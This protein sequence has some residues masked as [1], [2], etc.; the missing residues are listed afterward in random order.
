MND[1][2]EEINNYDLDK[3]M[4]QDEFDEIL[5]TVS[6][7]VPSSNEIGTYDQVPYMN[8]YPKSKE[9][10]WKLYSL[11]K[12]QIFEVVFRT[13]HSNAPAY[14]TAGD[15]T[16]PATGRTIIDEMEYLFEN[17]DKKLYSYLSAAWFMTSDNMA[18][19]YKSHRHSGWNVICDLCTEI[20]CL[21]NDEEI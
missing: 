17:R 7:Y 6:D 10:W 8:E 2:L 4:E 14:E 19:E 1:K 20:G 9:E 16:T 11:Y 12:N 18:N 13:M 3:L 5:K 21:Y 15:D